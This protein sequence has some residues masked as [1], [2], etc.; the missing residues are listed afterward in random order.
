MET[1]WMVTVATEPASVM[2]ISLVLRVRNVRIQMPSDPTVTKSATVFMEC[3]IK[4]QM[5]TDSVGV[6]LRTLGSAVIKSVPVVVPV[7]HIPTVKDL[8][9]LPS[10]NVFLDSPRRRQTLVNEPALK[11]T[12]M[13][14]LSAL[15]M[16]QRSHAP[17]NPNMWVMAA[18]AYPETLA[19]RTTVAVP[20]NPPSVSS[21][22]PTSPVVSVSLACHL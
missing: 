8:E 21:L 19:L 15:L 17:A 16:G 18:C 6:R 5:V 3:V 20:L 13:S 14:M 22:D 1:V 7:L 4:A 11:T 10:V 9:M 2:T 12:V